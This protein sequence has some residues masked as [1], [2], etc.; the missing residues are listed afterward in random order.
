MRLWRIS[1]YADLSGLGGLRYSAR[2]HTRG[3]PILYTAEHPA[4][5]LAEFLVHLDRED[6][7]DTFQL[8]TFEVD[9]IVTPEIVE[10]KRLPR[11]W[12][13]DPR[14]TRARGDEWLA[15][16]RGLLLRVPSSIVPDAYNVLV[17][18][19]HADARKMRIAR[20]TKVPLD[21]RLV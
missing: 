12:I 13:N 17:N 5:A 7:P 18:P 9:D 16:G 21:D 8:L 6:I 20:V 15:S 10:V 19:R 1:N 11:G 3:H 2:W 4:G 14:V